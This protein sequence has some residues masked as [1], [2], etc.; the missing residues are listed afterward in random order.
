MKALLSATLLT[1]L[2]L[3]GTPTLAQA[4]S[5]RPQASSGRPACYGVHG[6]LVCNGASVPRPSTYRCL[7]FTRQVVTEI[8]VDEGLQGGVF[9]SAGLLSDGTV[10]GLPLGTVL[11]LLGIWSGAGGGFLIWYASSPYFHPGRRCGYVG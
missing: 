2:L 11:G 6:R 7:N 10:V 4:A 1:G 5:D 9:S 3:L 8:G